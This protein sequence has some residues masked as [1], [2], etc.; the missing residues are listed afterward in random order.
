M[1]RSGVL[2]EQVVVFRAVRWLQI[3]RVGDFWVRGRFVE[4]NVNI[5]L[6]DI[7]VVFVFVCFSFRVDDVLSKNG[8][9]MKEW[10]NRAGHNSNS[11]DGVHLQSLCLLAL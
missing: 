1:Q 4:G 3:R 6:V 5:L 7:F 10:V 8:G 2:I 11:K 9:R